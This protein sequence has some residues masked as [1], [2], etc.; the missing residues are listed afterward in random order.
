[1]HSF[2][3]R[4]WA[5]SHQSVLV[6]V[7]PLHLLGFGPGQ[8]HRTTQDIQ[9]LLQDKHGHLINPGKRHRWLKLSKSSGASIDLFLSPR[10]PVGHKQRRPR[11][12]LPGHKASSPERLAAAFHHHEGAIKSSLGVWTAGRADGPFSRRLCRRCW[13]GEHPR[14]AARTDEGLSPLV[15]H[16]SCHVPL[17]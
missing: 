6:D 2:P 16:Q 3:W 8:N 14:A 5:D 9:V 1:M 11:S 13:L 4:F 10:K 7:C 12:V 15:I 17:F